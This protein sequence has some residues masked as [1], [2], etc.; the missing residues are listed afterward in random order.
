MALPSIG[1]V[2][3][4]GGK[5]EPAARLV[6]NRADRWRQR[7]GTPTASERVVWRRFGRDLRSRVSSAGARA[8]A[9]LIKKKKKKKEEEDRDHTSVMDYDRSIFYYLARRKKHLRIDTTLN[10]KYSFKNI[11]RR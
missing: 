10:R 9:T 8:R 6:R 7:P 5:R 2:S 4:F 1:V 11:A 3:P